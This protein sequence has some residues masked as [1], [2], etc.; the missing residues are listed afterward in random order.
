VAEVILILA[1]GNQGKAAEL[2]ALLRDVPGLELSTLREHP[3]I[4]LPPEEGSSL[5]ENARRK[6]EAVSRAAGQRALAD[7]SGLFVP[8]LG[9]APGVRSARFAGEGASDAENVAKLLALLAG[10]PAP[11]RRAAFRCVLAYARPGAPTACFT[12]EVEGT[13]VERPRGDG[14]FGYDPVFLVPEIGETFGEIP[15]ERKRRVSHR[16]LAVRAF[17]AALLAEAPAP[18]KGGSA[19]GGN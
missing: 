13:I 11:E 16:A 5:E 4:A 8:A 1:T 6:A 2:A 7:D 12:G 18:A 3:G 15:S 9:G 14:G 10:R 19:P 17:R